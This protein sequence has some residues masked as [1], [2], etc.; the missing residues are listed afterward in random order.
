MYKQ[1]IAITGKKFTILLKEQIKTTN[2]SEKCFHLSAHVMNIFTHICSWRDK[3]IIL[4]TIYL[5]ENCFHFL[6]FINL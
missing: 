3:D 5:N 2:L 4:K 6:F 1:L